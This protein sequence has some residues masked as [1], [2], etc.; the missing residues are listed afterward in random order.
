MLLSEAKSSKT[1][2]DEANIMSAVFRSNTRDLLP[3]KRLPTKL[4]GWL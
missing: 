2:C 4:V 3:T 1:M